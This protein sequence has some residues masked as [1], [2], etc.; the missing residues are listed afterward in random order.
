[1]KP[2][3]PYFTA[4]GRFYILALSQSRVRLFSC[5]RHQVMEIELVDVP[6]GLEEALQYDTKQSQ[7]QFH[8]Q[9]AGG[10][11]PRPAM[12]H[13]HGVGTDD[14]KDEILRYFRK[15]DRGLAGI[16]PDVEVPLV[17]AGVDFLLPIYR[18]A[19]SYQ[20]LLAD[21]VCGNPDELKAEELHKKALDVVLPELGRGVQEAA[22]RYRELAGKGA[23]AAGVREVVPAAAYGRVETLFAATDERRPG[24]FDRK[25]GQ[26]HRRR[27][28]GPKRLGPARSRRCGDDP[29]RRP[30]VCGQAGRDARSAC[31]RRGHPPVLTRS[32]NRCINGGGLC[33]RRRPNLIRNTDAMLIPVA[34]TIARQISDEKSAHP[35][36]AL[37]TLGVTY[38][39]SLGGWPPY[40]AGPPM[41]SHPDFWRMPFWMKSPRSRPCP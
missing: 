3:L 23:T 5:T 34:L 18:R 33:S 22:G 37:L 24:A 26:R 12:F 39:A 8:T 9:T 38:S 7:L 28:R 40:S 13:G 29:A 10:G 30:G 15:V 17:L 35:L 36:L 31:G 11:G 27:E 6:E 16:L 1:V 32:F 2:L 20:W 25:A 41:R 4:A 14:R 19:S 21:A